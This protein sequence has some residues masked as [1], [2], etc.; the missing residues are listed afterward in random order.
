[1]A[2]GTRRSIARI[3]E[4]SQAFFFQPPIEHRK[5]FERNED[6]PADFNKVR[7]S[8]TGQFLGNHGDRGD[9][10]GNILTGCAIPAGSGLNEPAVLV[11]EIHSESVD[12]GFAD[13]LNIGGRHSFLPR[14][15]LEPGFHFVPVERVLE[16]VHAFPM[17]DR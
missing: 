11:P 5:V 9:V 3:C 15:S 1:M 2:E 17:Y 16:R 7:I 13:N 10:R 12:L 8:L 6:F 14:D 4:C